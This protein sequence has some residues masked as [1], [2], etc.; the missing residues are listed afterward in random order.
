[1]KKLL[2]N[3]IFKKFITLQANQRG[4]AIF[5]VVLILTG[6][7]VAVLGINNLVIKGI[8]L[9]RNIAWSAPAYFAAETGMEKALYET[10]KDSVTEIP[11]PENINGEFNDQEANWK[12]YFKCTGK[13][14]N[15]EY[16]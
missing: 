6:I 14:E 15:D 10:R 2:I 5:L 12:V 1:M 7:L 11:K 8:K 4:S 9:S 3:L 13:D 16:F